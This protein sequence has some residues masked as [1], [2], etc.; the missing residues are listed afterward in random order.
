VSE[1]E[2]HGGQN[3]S[4][5]DYLRVVRRRKWIILQAVLLVP[6]VAIALSLQQEKVFEASSQVL[7]VQQNPADQFNP[8]NSGGAQPPDRI[9]QTQADLARVPEV[10][11]RTLEAAGVNRTV[12]QFLANSSAS[13]RTN[14]DLLLLSVRDHVPRVAVE[15]ATAYA[16]A[17]ALYRAKFDTAPYQIS[18]ERA[19]EQLRQ[20]AAQGD[21][22]TDAYREL[23]AKR[24]GVEQYMAL[25]TRNAVPVQVPDQATQIQPKPV[26]NGILGL[27]LGIVLG[28]ALAFL[29]EALDTRVRTAEEVGEKLHLPLLSRIPAPA[30]KLRNANRLVMK[31]DPHGVQAEAFRTLRTNIEFVNLDLNARTIMITSAIQA[32]GKSTTAA[33]LAIAFARMGKRVALV[34]LDL[35]RPFMDSFFDFG[36]RPGLTHVA[37]GHFS[38]EAATLHVALAPDDDAERVAV[39][40]ESNGHS[41]GSNGHSKLDGVLDVISSGPLPPDGG[42]FVGSKAVAEL[43]TTLRERYDLV[44]IDSPPLLRVNDAVAL[45]SRVDAM[46]IVVRLETLRRPILKELAR[47]LETTRTPRLGFILTGLDSDEEAYAYGYRGSGYSYSEPEDEARMRVEVTS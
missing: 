23:Q 46:A 27:G 19:D 44:L 35:R 39:F 7:L 26:R 32:E 30:R 13:S 22:G 3:A 4:L 14:S 18:L 47:V 21:K 9:A 17:F 29:R 1:G 42:D 33:N 10:A 6:A 12:D 5:R 37:R 8:S 41:N 24:D 36:D 31:A 15:L 20:M 25:L 2:A 11:Q 45:S 28:M 34:D 38:I 43:L 40:A 16:R